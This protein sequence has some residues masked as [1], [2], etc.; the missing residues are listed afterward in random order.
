MTPPSPADVR[1]DAELAR[2]QS[3]EEKPC[4]SGCPAGC[5][6]ADFIQMARGGQ[7]SDYQR[8]AAHILGHN[9][10]GGVCG[11][12][13]PE[14]L[15]MARCSRRELGAPVDIPLVQAAIVRRARELGPLPRPEPLPSTGERIAVVGAGPAGLGAASVLARAGHAVHVFDRARQAGGVARLIPRTRLDPAVL[16]Q[17]LAELVALGDVR[18]VL[19]EAVERP[20]QLLTRG[21]EAVIVA[22]GLGEPLALDV[23]G[24]R[25][26]IPWTRVLGDD[27]PPLRGRRVAVVG[28]GGVALD[29]AEAA[30]TQGAAH[31]ELLALKSLSELAATRRDRERLFAPGLHVS[32][33]VRVGAIRRDRGATVLEL[34]KVDLP[35]GQAFHPS[36]LRDLRHR[37]HERRDLDTVVV[38]IGGAASLPPDRHPRIVHAGDL[39][40]G[41]TTVVEALASGKR[42][43]LE[44]HRLLSGQE[45]AACPDRA[46]CA[47][48]AG[49]PKRATCPEWNGP[50]S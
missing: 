46:S 41:P 39:A 32:G 36:R 25:R 34:R 49:C 33:R 8:A 3:C 31:V 4:R 19:G 48:G 28:D 10:L 50:P 44:V 12:V 7:P 47:D 11:A 29:C 16:E 9:P 30:L 14:T 43:A 6:P 22:A 27:P 13:C 40:T 5:S 18:L 2:C 21:Y 17:D 45:F 37:P 42:A 26:A 20:R 24:A 35:P 1:V 15:C 38:A 23:P